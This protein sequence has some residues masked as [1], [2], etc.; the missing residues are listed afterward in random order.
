VIARQ[1]S[2]EKDAEQAYDEALRGQRQLAAARSRPE[3]RRALA[4]TLNNLGLLRK[5][6]GRADAEAAFL[7][8]AIIQER[9]AREDPRVPPSRREVAR[10]YNNRGAYLAGARGRAA[11]AEKA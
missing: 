2:C 9:L 1:A 10:T 4:R 7:E 5:R 8:A 11:A 6:T 3:F